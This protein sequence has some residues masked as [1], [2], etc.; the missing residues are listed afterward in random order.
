MSA[1][2][3]PIRVA[4][5]I[6]PEHGSYA[7]L[8]SAVIEADRLGADAIYNWDHFWPLSRA[9]D[10]RH[11]EAW[12]TI[13]SWAEV[14]PRSRIGTLVSCAGYRNPDLLADMA[15]TVDHISGGRLV[16][17]LGAGFREKEYVEYGY[18]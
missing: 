10:G 17:G 12:T 2:P 15:R 7:D 4:V 16:L 9:G 14:T 6:A 13:G 3:H 1:A 18:A 5:Q 8:R 11:Y